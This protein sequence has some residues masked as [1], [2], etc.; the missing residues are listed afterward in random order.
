LSFIENMT[1]NSRNIKVPSQNCVIRQDLVE[2]SANPRDWRVL[3][4]HPGRQH[5]HQAA[6]ALHEAG[7]LACYATGIPVSK[8]QFGW[9]GQRLLSKYSAY[10]DVDVPVQLTR[11]NMISPVTNRVV[12]PRIPYFG[13]PLLY[14]TYKMFDRWVARMIERQ[15]FDA[16]ICYETAALHTFKTAKKFG[17]K[18]I[19]DA[20]SLH[21]IEAD[22]RYTVALPRAYKEKVDVRKDAEVALADCIFATSDLAAESYR[23]HVERVPVK[24]VVLGVDIDRFRPAARDVVGSG[25]STFTFVFVGT[26]TLRKG[27]DLLIESVEQL[28]QEGLSFRVLVAGNID[29]SLLVGRGRA[30]QRIVQYGRVG[31]DEL[32]SIL[33]HGDCFILPS[34]FDSF[35]M[36]VPEAMACGLPVIVTDM[37]GAKQLVEE[38]RNGFVVPAGNREALVE[39]MRWSINNRMQLIQ[40]SVSARTA[41]ERVSWNHY[42]HR[43]AAAVEDV[44]LNR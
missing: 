6:L 40:M 19:L 43:F 18:C 23:A 27:F 37:V 25:T 8:L 2:S 38:G 31:H 34:R 35:G 28:L 10:D 17:I 9:F 5:S 42:R 3:I 36:V 22:Q 14:E 24:T 39:R 7:Y 12:A 26:A 15:R 44:L 13:G 41:A 1:M 16:V 21:R 33:R 20:A 29:K 11:L 30:L 4:A 32:V